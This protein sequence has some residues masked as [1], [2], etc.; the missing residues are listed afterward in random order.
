MGY[1]PQQ[2]EI[3]II[4][5]SNQDIHVSRSLIDAIVWRENLFGKSWASNLPSNDELRKMIAQPGQFLLDEVKSDLQTIQILLSNPESRR[6]VATKIISEVKNSFSSGDAM[7]SSAGLIFGAIIMPAGS[8]KFLEKMSIP[9]FKDEKYV[10]EMIKRIPDDAPVLSIMKKED[11]ADKLRYV[12]PVDSGNSLMDWMV[13]HIPPTIT[14]NSP[15]IARAYVERD[16]GLLSDAEFSQRALTSFA[17]RW[18]F[19]GGV[20]SGAYQLFSDDKNP[21]Q[22][23]TLTQ[24]ELV[25]LQS[26]CTSLLKMASS[27]NALLKHLHDEKGILTTDDK[28]MLECISL[29]LIDD[30]EKSPATTTENA[31]PI[32]LPDASWQANL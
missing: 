26:E 12:R 17:M 11:I 30:F 19:R 1:K 5:E 8:R 2:D 14:S 3:P 23:T 28:K 7:T 27:Y 10:Q 29:K 31:P 24:D 25:K 6:A 18:S 32:Q 20:V 13:D 4:S 22:Q 16:L 15:F 21:E 9:E